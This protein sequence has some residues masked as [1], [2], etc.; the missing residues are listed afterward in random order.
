MAKQK[1]I[2]RRLNALEALGQVT[3]ICSDKTGTLTEGKMVVTRYWVGGK[4]Y[5][6]AG[7]GLQPE[8]EIM[9][10]G[11]GAVQAVAQIKTD[12]AQCKSRPFRDR[13]LGTLSLNFLFLSQT[14]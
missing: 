2:V 9:E 14:I 7:K 8:G 5:D 13:K 1:A 4:E 12:K 11:T 3:N 6:V 10:K